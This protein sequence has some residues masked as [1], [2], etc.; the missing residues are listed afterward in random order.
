MPVIAAVI[1]C[2][3]LARVL[4]VPAATTPAQSVGPAS[5]IEI[6]VK[7]GTI[8]VYHG[9]TTLYCIPEPADMSSPPFFWTSMFAS[10][11]MGVRANGNRAI[12]VDGSA[13]HIAYSSSNSK[14]IRFDDSGTSRWAGGFDLEGPG[15]A[16]ITI[17]VG[18]SKKVIS[19]NVISLPLR[20]DMPR[21]KVVELLGHP[22]RTIKSD[23][24][25]FASVNGQP[26]D[27]VCEDWSYK[28]Y[29]GLVLTLDP[30][31]G[32]VHATMPEWDQIE[33]H[34]AFPGGPPR[35]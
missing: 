18:R 29:P 9:E 13:Y 6:E 20:Y 35:G 31:E 33:M 4:T 32:L 3:S 1:V 19:M 22:D 28:R 10:Y 14:V 17:S 34:F 25:Q 15:H 7:Q 27:V 16:G 5:P 21:S 8:K 30:L 23:W 2:T 24:V 12:E 11:F 26:V